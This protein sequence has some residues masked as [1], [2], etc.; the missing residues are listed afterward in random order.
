MTKPKCKIP[1]ENYE[2][3]CTSL[4]YSLDQ[5]RYNP[6][7]NNNPGCWLVQDCYPKLESV[8]TRM[9]H[10]GF[11]LSLGL[12]SEHDVDWWS[13]VQTGYQASM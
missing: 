3:F 12:V 13:R 2:G 11:L 7:L 1:L 4:G 9:L 10:W 6:P 5:S 8:P